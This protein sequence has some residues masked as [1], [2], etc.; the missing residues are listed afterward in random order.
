MWI[1][2]TAFLMLILGLAAFFRIPFSP[3]KAAFEKAVEE[4]INAS[5]GTTEKF[6]EAD[7]EKLPAPISAAADISEPQRW[8]TCGRR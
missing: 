7:I 8:N 2:I 1:A 3:T 6:T 4:K 5:A